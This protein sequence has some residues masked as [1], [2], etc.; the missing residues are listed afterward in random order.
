MK[1]FVGVVIFKTLLILKLLCAPRTCSLLGFNHHN[2]SLD[3]GNLSFEYILAGNP[4][5]E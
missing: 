1:P 5:S 2:E 3:E 4:K